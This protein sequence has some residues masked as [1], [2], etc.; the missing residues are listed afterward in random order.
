MDRVFYYYCRGIEAILAVALSL[1]VIMVF[2]NV[3]LRYLF[4]SGIAFSEELSRWLFVW[5]TFLGA[6]VA[7]HERGH[8]GTDFLTGRLPPAGK[9]LCLGVGYLLMLLTC[10]LLFKGALDQTKINWDVSAPSS[11]ASVGIFYASGIVFS[12]SA[13]VMLAVDLI[14]LV[15]G[16]V[17]EEELIIVRESEEQ[18]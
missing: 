13:F 1:M 3:V 14:K 6:V 5:V 2:G 17:P 4:N 18:A 16:R 9:K 15:T 12:V 10:W 8:L 11:G 7:L